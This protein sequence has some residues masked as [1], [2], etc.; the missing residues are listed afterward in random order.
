MALI[1][2]P[3][4]PMSRITIS[5]LHP[6]KGGG[7]KGK[8]STSGSKGGSTPTRKGGSSTRL[9]FSSGVSGKT[10]SSYS[11]GGGKPFKLGSSSPFSG[12]LAGGG[13]RAQVFGNSRYGSGYPYGGSGTYIDYRP[14]PY[15]FYPV[16]IYPDY[17]GSDTYAHF[18]DTQRPGGNVSVV[19]LQGNNFPHTPEI[20][21]VVGD[22]FSVSAVLDAVVIDC[23]VQNTTL[24]S[25]DLTANSYPEPEQII[26]WYRAST[27]GLSLDSYNNSAS[28]PSNMPS[29]N[30][31]A[32]LPLS[33]DT[34]LP[35]GLNMTF[36]SCLNMTIGASI[37]LV[38]PPRSY[39]YRRGILIGIIL[40]AIVGFLFF[41]GVFIHHRRQRRLRNLGLVKPQTSN[42]AKTGPCD[43]PCGLIGFFCC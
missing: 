36:L 7:S 35:N 4:S 13:T 32:P 22:R 38:D 27:F 31:T 34:P 14:L 9:G 29:S 24:I 1:Y 15:V 40:A 11:P 5:S 19:I 28:L 20:Y 39:Q 2:S 8:G 33:A 10:M 23:S 3:D 6:R 37:P 43:L 30:N 25:F 41:V 42:T 16:P 17:Y 12:R 21:R 18:N 26:Q